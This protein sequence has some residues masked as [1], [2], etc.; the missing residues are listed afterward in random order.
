MKRPGANDPRRL[1]G[2]AVR[3]CRQEAGLSQEKLAAMASIHR[4]YLGGIERGERNVAIVNMVKIA[5]A[6]GMPLSKLVSVM[7]DVD[8]K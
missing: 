4:N 8:R 1:F 5:K 3:K 2:E 6:L 7:E